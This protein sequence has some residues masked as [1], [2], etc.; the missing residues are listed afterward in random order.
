MDLK[1]LCDQIRKNIIN[2]ASKIELKEFLS[3]M[4]EQNLIC[5]YDYDHL[6][7]KCESDRNFTFLLN[8]DMYGTKVCSE[9]IDFLHKTEKDLFNQ[10]M[11]PSEKTVKPIVDDD[12]RTLFETAKKD[13]NLIRREYVLLQKRINPNAI[14]PQLFQDGYLTRDDLESIF[15]EKTRIKRAGALMHELVGRMKTTQIRLGV[16]TSF[17]KA[18]SMYQADLCE[19]FL[20]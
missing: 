13:Q 3:R 17:T 18:L 5:F 11:K 16:F 10:L 9:F 12:L 15:V 19:E 1:E 6:L 4:Y 20:S 14:A 8:I 2:I 7:F